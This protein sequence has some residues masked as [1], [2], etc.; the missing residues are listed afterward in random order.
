MAPIFFTER[1]SDASTSSQRSRRI[2]SGIAF[3]ILAIAIV[4]FSLS[5]Q[6]APFAFS[7]TGSLATARSSHT[8][9][10]LQNGK[11]LVAGGIAGFNSQLASA[12]LYDP[13]TDTWTPT[14]SMGTVR[15]GHTATLLQNGK[16][17][18]TGGFNSSA[19][20]L[21]SAELYDP[22]T[23]TWSATGNLIQRRDLHTATLLQN[24]QV[25]VAA[26]R[27]Q[28]ASSAVLA[29]AELYDPTTGN[30]T[31]T[32]SM[33]TVRWGHSMTLLQTGKVLVAGGAPDQTNT[34]FLASA[35]LYNPASGTWSATGSLLNA[36]DNHTAT[37]L[38]DGKVLVAGGRGRVVVVGGFSTKILSSAELYDAGSGT[39]TSTGSLLAARDVHT[40][41]LLPDG[42]VIAAG[43]ANINY[44]ASAELYSPAHGTWSATGGLVTARA[45]HTATLMS[46]SQ[47]LVAGGITGGP[48][49]LAS[50]ELFAPVT[51]LANL[52]SR[53]RIENGDKVLFAGLIVTG[54]DPKRIIVRALGPSLAIQDKLADPVLELYDSSGALLE[55]NDNWME[56][57]NKQAIIESS[58]APSNTLE[59]AI[60]RVLPP[61]AYT[62]I[63][64]GANNGTGVGVIE[65]Y[66]LDASATSRLA[67]ISTRGFVQTGDNA[68]IAGMIV[69]GEAAQKVIVRATGSS[70]TVPE[71]L[72]NPT[73]E[74]RDSNGALLEANDDW[75][76]S[77]NK[78]AISDSTVAPTNDLEPAIARILTPAAYTAIV[79]GVNG[80]TG[81]A[82]VEVYA[83]AN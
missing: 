25:L 44:L 23:G 16:V 29:S 12:E 18:V 36:R 79:S 26:G 76:D 49:I 8:S 34:T 72:A 55:T 60:V 2:T 22:A 39:W 5:A 65:L 19:G 27:P 11:V 53:V 57:A 20:Q 62:A 74:L 78:Q 38:L 81:I 35:E 73:L 54:T 6:G 40:A 46:N 50:A 42:C 59:S 63:V 52:S 68:L 24:G 75:V 21:A 31:A 33:G 28:G 17:L 9:T 47:L 13:A 82:V 58:V 69:A 30:W 70:L 14:G 61:A 4:L 10:L 43:G 56:S 67:N 7:K 66:D 77:P 3:L 64:R 51:E 37:L 83:L 45:G 71:K 15:Q 1:N 48:F 32:G 80:T 41:T